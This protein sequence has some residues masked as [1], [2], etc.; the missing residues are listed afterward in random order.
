MCHNLLDQPGQFTCHKF[1]DGCEF[2]VYGTPGCDEDVLCCTLPVSLKELVRSQLVLQ[3]HPQ[4]LHTVRIHCSC[5][6]PAE[7]T[8]TEASNSAYIVPSCDALI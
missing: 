4:L 7:A 2:T 5:H 8:Q 6:W 3:T 1:T